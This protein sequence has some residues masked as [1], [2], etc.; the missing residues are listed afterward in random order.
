MDTGKD[1]ISIPVDRKL[2]LTIRE[3]SEYSNI[4]LNKISAMLNDQMC[5]FVLYVGNRKLVKGKEFEDY[6]AKHSKI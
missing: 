1:N 6:I 5:D 3:A 2:T 4:G